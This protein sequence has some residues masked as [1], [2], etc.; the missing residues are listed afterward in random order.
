MS[1][2][3]GTEVTDDQWKPSALGRWWMG[4]W[5]KSWETTV[6]GMRLI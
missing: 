1:L 4:L 6:P 2:L 3:A 5:G